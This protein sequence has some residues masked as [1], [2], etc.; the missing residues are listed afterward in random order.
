VHIDFKDKNYFLNT[1]F[2]CIQFF[3]LNFWRKQ[4]DLNSK[5]APKHANT[6]A[7]WLGGNV[8]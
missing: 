5:S 2:I 4:V 7:A 3:R 8:L 1:D 6:K